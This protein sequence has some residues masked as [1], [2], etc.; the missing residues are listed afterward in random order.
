MSKKK[1]RLI[2]REV[3]EVAEAHLEQYYKIKHNVKHFYSNLEERTKRKFGMK[4]ADGMMAYKLSTKKAY[5]IS[6]EAK[7]HKTLPALKPY[8]VDK[9][10][11]RDSMW[12][13]FLFCM[14]T[15][16]LFIAWSWRDAGYL[17]VLLPFGVWAIATLIHAFFFRNSYKYQEMQVIHQVFQYPGNEQWL[18][19]SEDAF[20]MIDKK[21]QSNL[22]KICEARGVGVI[23]V[24]ANKR[25]NVIVKPKKHKRFFGDFLIYYHYE[26]EIRR[27][28]GIQ[29]RKDGGDQVWD[30]QMPEWIE[31]T[32]QK[33]KAKEHEKFYS[34]EKSKNSNRSSPKKT[35]VDDNLNRTT[36]AEN[37]RSKSVSRKRSTSKKTTSKKTTEKAKTEA[38]KP[39][40]RKR[41][42]SKKTAEETKK[43]TTRKRSTK[44]TTNSKSK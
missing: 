12:K 35:E 7:S 29:A 11:Y 41:S 16:V 32:G 26:N 19:F 43:K 44:K 25:V 23:M 24:D 38:K 13:G 9:L 15:G 33:S 14:L 10:W 4:R 21:L 37:P 1:V 39:A 5:V 36:E 6:M 17:R 27:F 31:Q 2:E 22:F 8:R 3:Q 28:L 30:K 42:T 40:T 34:N 20:D 18:S